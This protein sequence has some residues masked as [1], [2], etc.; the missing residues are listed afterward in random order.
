VYVALR[1]GSTDSARS[2]Y[3]PRPCL[4]MA[5]G[6]RG[7]SDDQA[8]RRSQGFLRRSSPTCARRVSSSFASTACT[9]FFTVATLRWSSAAISLFV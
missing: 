8:E 3:T 6:P 4:S 1:P 2:P 9:W 5:V 7:L